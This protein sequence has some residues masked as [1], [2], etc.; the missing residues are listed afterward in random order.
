[1]QVDLKLA[2][3]L[4]A[5]AQEQAHSPSPDHVVA[6]SDLEPDSASLKLTCICVG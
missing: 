1:M 6:E 3:S 4:A 5:E 2:Q